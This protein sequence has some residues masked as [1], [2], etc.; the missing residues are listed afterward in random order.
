M[1]EVQLI[2]ADIAARYRE[3]RI[4]VVSA[5]AP[6]RS[7]AGPRTI[8]FF[9]RRQGMRKWKCFYSRLWFWQRQ[10]KLPRID[11]HLAWRDGGDQNYRF[12]RQTEIVVTDCNLLQNALG[13]DVRVV[14]CDRIAFAPHQRGTQIGKLLRRVFYLDQSNPLDGL[15]TEH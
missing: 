3:Q 2:P 10:P 6:S 13:D 11:Q 7:M 15:T 9:A 8:T 4:K 5:L 12:V 14:A 1:I